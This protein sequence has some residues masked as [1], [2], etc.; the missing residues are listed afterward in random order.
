MQKNTI[1]V[2][3]NSGF[4][5]GTLSSFL[6]LA[7]QYPYRPTIKNPVMGLIDLSYLKAVSV[8]V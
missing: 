7:V 2:A 8:D 6:P 4:H 5:K 3:N 1:I